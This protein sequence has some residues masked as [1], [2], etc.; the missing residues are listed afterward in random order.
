MLNVMA[1]DPGMLPQLHHTPFGYG[2]ASREG[3][4]NKSSI[5]VVSNHTE[6]REALALPFT[7]TIYVNG[8]IER[9]QLDNGTYPR[10]SSYFYP[11]TSTDR[12]SRNMRILY[13][14]HERRIQSIRLYSIPSQPQRDLCL[15]RR[16]RYIPEHHLRRKECHGIP[17][18]PWAPERLAARG[19]QH[20]ESP[21]RILAHE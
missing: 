20:P 14:C 12:Y 11:L 19:I 1:G 3:S 15:T 10:S 9:S 8:T 2:G 4:T 5:Y 7:K 6:L 21:S 18:P 13:H 17:G 16:G